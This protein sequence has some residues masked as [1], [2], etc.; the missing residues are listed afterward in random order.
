MPEVKEVELIVPQGTTFIYRVTY[1]DPETELPINITGYSSEFRAGDKLNDDVVDYIATSQDDISITGNLGL[2]ELKI[3]DNVTD[4]W[5][6]SKL[7]FNW[8]ITSPTGE[9]VRLTKGILVLDKRV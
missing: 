4:S 3:P 8:D 1:V 6:K 9:T 5:T 2:L 7:K